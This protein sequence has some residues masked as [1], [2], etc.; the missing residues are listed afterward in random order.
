MFNISGF[1]PSSRAAFL[2]HCTALEQLFGPEKV[3]KRTLKD[4]E[5]MEGDLEQRAAA[6]NTEREKTRLGRLKLRLSNLKRYS[7]ASSLEE[8]ITNL[9]AANDIQRAKEI[10]LELREI[11]QIRNRLAHAGRADLG[12]P[13]FDFRLCSKP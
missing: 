2:V 9:L 3:D 5:D 8:G 6:A 13:L 4:I 10:K 11:S 12:E 1:E 7:I